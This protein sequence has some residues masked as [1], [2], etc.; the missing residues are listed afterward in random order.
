MLKFLIVFL[1]VYNIFFYNF[2]RLNISF[3]FKNKKF[4]WNNIYVYYVCFVCILKDRGLLVYL[5]CYGEVGVVGG[6]GKMKVKCCCLW[7][8]IK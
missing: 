5:A 6:E 8:S 4:R 7:R 3:F 1:N 2:L